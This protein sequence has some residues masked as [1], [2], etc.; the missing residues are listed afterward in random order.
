MGLGSSRQL[1]PTEPVL[2]WGK[3]AS[4]QPHGTSP[5]VGSGTCTS[6]HCWG[7]GVPSSCHPFQCQLS[8]PCLPVLQSD[9]LR[10]L[11]TTHPTVNAEDLLKVKKFTKDFGQEG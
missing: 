5:R 8:A 9:M 10:S 3:G 6:Q 1:P 7:E 11:A 4:P 2:P